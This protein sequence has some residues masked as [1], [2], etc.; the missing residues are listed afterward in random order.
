MIEQLHRSV[1]FFSHAEVS[2]L[3]KDPIILEYDNASG[4]TSNGIGLKFLSEFVIRTSKKPCLIASEMT[5]F[6]NFYDK[7]FEIKLVE[8]PKGQREPPSSSST[9]NRNKVHKKQFEVSPKTDRKSPLAFLDDL[10]SEYMRVNFCWMNTKDFFEFDYQLDQSYKDQPAF[11]AIHYIKMLFH[12]T[13]FAIYADATI[14]MSTMKPLRYFY[15]PKNVEDYYNNLGKVPSLKDK[16][17][18]NFTKDTLGMLSRSKLYLGTD[19]FKRGALKISTRFGEL[20]EVMTRL[21][22]YLPGLFEAFPYDEFYLEGLISS[23][24]VTQPT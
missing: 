18:K 11:V 15:N 13:F 2:A 12:S 10:V 23:L 14:L 6:Y 19:Q 21:D 9:D 22:L 16:L 24:G 17:F 7:H 8:V 20:T 1:A 4:F 5:R 3:T